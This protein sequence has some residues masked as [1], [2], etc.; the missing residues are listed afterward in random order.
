MKLLRTLA[1]FLAPIALA[2]CGGDGPSAAGGAPQSAAGSTQPQPPEGVPAG[3]EPL[4]LPEP[5]KAYNNPQPRDNI[6][7]GGTLTLPIGGFGPNFNPLNA[8]GNNGEVTAILRWMAPRLW[9]YTP[10]GGVAPNPDYLLSVEQTSESPETFKLTLNPKARWNDGTPIDWTAFDATWKTQNGSDAR[11]NPASTDGYRSIGSVAKGE[12][13]NEVIVTFKE[14]FYPFEFVFAEIQH[15]KNLDPEFYKTGWVN[16]LNPELLAG[17]FTLEA[18]NADSLTLVRNPKWWGDTAKLG[19]WSFARWRLLPRS[20]H[21]KTAR[22][23]APTW[24]S[25]TACAK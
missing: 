9:N 4:P 22:S 24:R 6:Q 7:D 14:P 15:P 3:T 17:P 19:E 10:S 18:L 11:Y 1:F 16:N 2:A 8:D 20:T 25:A 23:T 21:S 5:G 12:K 13:D